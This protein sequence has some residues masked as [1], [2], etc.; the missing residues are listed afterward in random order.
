[1]PRNCCCGSGVLAAL[2]VAL[3]SAYRLGARH[4]MRA[5]ATEGHQLRVDLAARILHP[6]RLRTTQRTGELLSI[7]STD[8]DNTSYLLD[9]IPPRIAG[10]ITAIVVCATV[11]LTIDVPLGL[12]VLLGTPV[13]LFV[14]HFGGPVITRRS[15]TSRSSPVRPPRCRRT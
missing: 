1:M 10:A 5:I 4:L 6:Q 14:L 9:Y 13:I 8:A 15:P 2:F 3:T 12:A 11:L 7:A